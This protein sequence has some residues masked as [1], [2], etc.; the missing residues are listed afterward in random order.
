MLFISNV[1][2]E[3]GYFLDNEYPIYTYDSEI[4]L[5][6]SELS[7]YTYYFSYINDSG[8]ETML[9]NTVTFSSSDIKKIIL[10]I[11]FPETIPSDSIVDISLK[12]TF[13]SG[14][15]TYRV[16][17][18]WNMLSNTSTRFTGFTVSSNSSTFVW[19]A[20][21]NNLVCSD[22]VTRLRL[23]FYLED[24]DLDWGIYLTDISI[25]IS[26]SATEQEISNNVS[27]ILD[28][29][30]NLPSSIASAIGGFFDNVVGAINNIANNIL[31]GLKSLFIPSDG[32]FN[33]VSAD[34]K[35]FFTDRFSLITDLHNYIDRLV[36]IF[37]TT[38]SGIIYFPG[39]EFGGYTII[40]A[41][42]VQIIP[43][44][45]EFL[46][47]YIHMGVKILLVGALV[48]LLYRKVEGVL[49]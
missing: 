12:G 25:T 24:F 31:D 46:I 40:Q 49:K 30:K 15:L 10:T 45:L 8:I 35:T 48:T 7:G 11:N 2:A 37:Q 16:S 36:N 47:E 41:Q 39:V 1:Y 4:S 3:S 44:E 14:V 9:Y 22:S 42:D 38:S 18:L 34:I 28:Y 33:E 5:L 43:S 20:N 6:S 21:I 13:G 32:Y 26:G 27:S 17:E 23:G 29:I 19:R